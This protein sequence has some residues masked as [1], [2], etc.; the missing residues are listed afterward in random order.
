MA[1][2]GVEAA[3]TVRAREMNVNNGCPA[4]RSPASASK[5][6]WAKEAGIER[7]HEFVPRG[8]EGA[9]RER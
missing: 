9:G 5:P 4:M 6:K 2:R 8:C 3:E 7:I 1:Q